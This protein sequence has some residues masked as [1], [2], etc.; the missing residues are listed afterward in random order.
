M[1]CWIVC[2]SI[3]RGFISLRYEYS[4][5]EMQSENAKESALKKLERD[6]KDIRDG[7]SY[8]NKD[9]ES[10]NMSLKNR[11]YSFLKKKEKS[12]IILFGSQYV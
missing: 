2:I 3:S 10:Y 6:I 12:R 9:V 1:P 4:L 11:L 8:A 5:N 7:I